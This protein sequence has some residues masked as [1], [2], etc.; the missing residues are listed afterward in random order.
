MS[1]LD[2][3]CG[4]PAGINAG[5]ASCTIEMGAMAFPVFEYKY[6]ADGVT[7]NGIDVTSVTVGSDITTKILA[8][9]A[10]TSRLFPTVRVQNPTVS[11]TDTNYETTANGDK[12][13]LD[14]EGGVYSFLFEYFGK[15]GV[16]QILREFKKMGCTDVVMYIATTDGNLWGTKDTMTGDTLY[17]Y[18]LSKETIDAYYQFA[19]PGAKART[20]VSFDIDRDVCFE[21]SYVITS[22]EMIATG[23]VKSTAFSPLVTGNQTVTNPSTTTWQSVIYEGFGTANNRNDVTGLAPSGSGAAFTVTDITAGLP[24]TALTVT[25]AVESPNGTYLITTT[26]LVSASDIIT[27]AVVASGYDVIDAEFTVV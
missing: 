3:V 23:G 12:F 9:T 22:A 11:R 20:M 7:R 5:V 17:G 6:S 1:A 27:I 10:V 21:N 16:F 4:T 15:D 13:K 2:C 8:S 18:D 14:G 24:G 26:E 25:G 19:V